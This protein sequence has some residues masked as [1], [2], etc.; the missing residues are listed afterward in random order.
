L[1]YVLLLPGNAALDRIRAGE[2]VTAE[3][4]E[5]ILRS[6]TAALGWIELPKA[7]IDLGLTYYLMARSA[8]DPGADPAAYL[9]EAQQQLEI[10]LTGEPANASAWLWLADI[11]QALGD[12]QQAAEALRLAL[13]AA[14]RDVNLAVARAGMALRFWDELPPNTKVIAARDAQQA[15]ASPEAGA[16]VVEAADRGRLGPLH[17]ALAGDSVASAKLSALLA[18]VT[19][20]QENPMS[21]LGATAAGAS[22]A[23][24]ASTSAVAAMTVQDFLSAESNRETASQARYFEGF[25]DALYDFNV[26]MKEV[27][28]VV[29][30]PEGQARPI[31]GLELQRRV[32]ADLARKRQTEL[33]FATYASQT[34]L[35]L[36]A[37]EVLTAAHPCNEEDGMEPA[38]GQ[39]PQP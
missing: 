16:F 33:D 37:L 13:L 9:L 2:I 34:S 31:V 26:I 22:A 28:V 19:A 27:G 14:P 18:S 10:G 24:L 8:A 39:P 32:S 30:C 5:R 35:G 25:G 29:F 4:Y 21:A 38:P 12:T 23:L 6:R 17:Q 36:V 7:R 20:S 3:G 15:M 1:A 11:N